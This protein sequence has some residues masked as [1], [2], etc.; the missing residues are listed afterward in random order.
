MGKR[1]RTYNLWWGKYIG[2]KIDHIFLWLL[3]YMG[4]KYRFVGFPEIFGTSRRVRYELAPCGK[5]RHVEIFIHF[6]TLCLHT[7]QPGTVLKI[8]GTP[9]SEIHNLIFP[10]FLTDFFKE[11]ETFVKRFQKLPWLWNR[12]RCRAW[13][14]AMFVFDPLISK[15]DWIELL[16]FKKW[17]QKISAVAILL[18]PK[19]L[20]ILV[21]SQ[22]EITQH[23]LSNATLRILELLG[24]IYSTYF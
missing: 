4:C 24:G 7:R 20:W 22:C 2:W 8:L 21:R 9:Q 6:D 23:G 14:V 1:L 10:K 5:Q 16:L 17:S 13:E 18:G 3:K 15:K 11:H 12:C 19:R